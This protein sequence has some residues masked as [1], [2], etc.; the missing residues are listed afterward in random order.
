MAGKEKCGDVFLLKFRS[1]S[2]STPG[3]SV[4]KSGNF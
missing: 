4:E 3:I 1:L 2:F